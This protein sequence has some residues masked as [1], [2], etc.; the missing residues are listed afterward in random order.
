[1]KIKKVGCRKSTFNLFRAVAH[2]LADEGCRGLVN[3]EQVPAFAQPSAPLQD[4]L[5]AAQK[6]S[7][8]AVCTA[9]AQAST[10]RRCRSQKDF[11]FAGAS[12]RSAQSVHGC[13][14]RAPAVCVQQAR[15]AVSI[16][17][18]ERT[19]RAARCTPDSCSR[20]QHA[21]APTPRMPLRHGVQRARTVHTLALTSRVSARH[22]SSIPLTTRSLHLARF[23]AMRGEGR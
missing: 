22:R 14:N 21:R 12:A 17:A 11:A 2:F 8:F 9:V 13:R 10:V 20:A 15:A 1:M 7:C 23:D 18:R 19:E 4:G 16:C 5:K 6:S 3:S